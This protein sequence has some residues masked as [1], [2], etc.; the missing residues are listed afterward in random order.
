VSLPVSGHPPDTTDSL[1]PLPLPRQ[2][3]LQNYP[4]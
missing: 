1:T 2:S 4:R 3:R